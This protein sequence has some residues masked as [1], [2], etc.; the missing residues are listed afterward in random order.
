MTSRSQQTGMRRWLLTS[1]AAMVAVLAAIPL[2]T[3]AS[4]SAAF[5]AETRVAEFNVAG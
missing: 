3:T 4:A 1:P 5:G 2:G